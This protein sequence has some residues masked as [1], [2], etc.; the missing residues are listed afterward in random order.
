MKIFPKGTNVG[1]T[2]LQSGAVIRMY[3]AFY[4]V[5]SIRGFTSMITTVCANIIMIWFFPT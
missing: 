2:H 4:N 3:L 5:T 1:T